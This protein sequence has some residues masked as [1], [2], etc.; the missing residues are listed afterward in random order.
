MSQLVVELGE[1]VEPLTIERDDGKDLAS[2]VK[3]YGEAEVFGTASRAA[4]SKRKAKAKA[5]LAKKDDK[6]KLVNTR[7]Q[8]IEI[9]TVFNPFSVSRSRLTPETRIE[10]ILAEA[11]KLPGANRKALEA[12][13]KAM[14]NG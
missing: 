14:L 6:G 1:G 7:Q 13:L 8:V 2:M 10:K 3:K 5:E 4:D 9:M 11:A 12:Q